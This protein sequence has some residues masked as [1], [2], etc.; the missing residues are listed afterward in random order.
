MGGAGQR[1]LRSASLDLVKRTSG[2][3]YNVENGECLQKKEAA[4][5]CRPPDRYQS[6]RLLQPAF[7]FAH[8]DN[9]RRLRRY[10]RCTDIFLPEFLPSTRSG[11][12]PAHPWPCPVARVS[13]LYLALTPGILHCVVLTPLALSYTRQ[14]SL[15]TP[16]PGVTIKISICCPRPPANLTFFS[17]ARARKR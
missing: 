1:E 16:T 10:I 8:H 7:V 11:P 2:V 13:Q 3:E 4:W 9:H 12:R 15:P 17:R 6:Q 14:S 5:L